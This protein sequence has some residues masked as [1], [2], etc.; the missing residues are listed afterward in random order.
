MSGVCH[1]SGYDD[2]GSKYYWQGSKPRS[3]RRCGKVAS[4][5]PFPSSSPTHLYEFCPPPSLPAPRPPITPLTAPRQRRSQRHHELIRRLRDCQAM[6]TA[7]RPAFRG[8][9]GFSL[10]SSL[11]TALCDRQYGT[12][13][14]PAP[15][16]CQDRGQRSRSDTGHR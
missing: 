4:M 7:S 15:R 16:G 10:T 11:E 2:L 6:L 13:P 1:F 9:G 8:G 12:G 5:R 3:L 14:W